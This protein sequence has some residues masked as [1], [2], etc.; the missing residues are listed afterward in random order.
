MTSSNAARQKNNLDA[1]DALNASTA[2]TLSPD[3]AARQQKSATAF[4]TISEVATE[5]GVPAHVLRFWESK[6]PQIRPLK[7]GG[8]RRYYRPEDVE[9]L[10][11]IRGLL[12][13]DRYTIKGVQKLLRSGGAAGAATL[14]QA[15]D[16]LEEVEQQGPHTRLNLPN[17]EARQNHPGSAMAAEEDEDIREDTEDT[18]YNFQTGGTLK[19]SDA[20][21]PDMAEFDREA[22]AILDE[23]YDIRS[24]LTELAPHLR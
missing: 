21:S 2:K 5:L 8:G 3:A 11:R 13:D 1:D 14:S 20:S 10:R 6:L 12:Y 15:L 23:L 17:A 18:S 19:T 24:L 22:H 7:R 16:A 9:L 4:R